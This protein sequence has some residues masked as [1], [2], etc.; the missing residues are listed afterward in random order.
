MD[1]KTLISAGCFVAFLLLSCAMA[2]ADTCTDLIRQPW[3]GAVVTSATRV[4]ASNG[5]PS[6]CKVKATAGK[7]TDIEVWLPDGWQKRFLHLGGGGL[8]GATPFDSMPAICRPHCYDRRLQQ[9]FALAGS[10]GGHRFGGALFGYDPELSED[11]AHAAI[12]TTAR[13]AK[14]LIAAYYGE[15]PTYSYFSGCSNGGR[16]ALNAAAKYPDE[17]DGIVAGAPTRNMAG[18]TAAWME[19]TPPRHVMTKG[20]ITALSKATV[21]ACDEQDGLVDGIISNPDACSFDPAELRCAGL[22]DDTCLTDEAIAYAEKVHSDLRLADGTL[23]Y[24]RTGPGL[25]SSALP[26]LW[27]S[28]YWHHGKS[29][30]NAITFRNPFHA[31]NLEADYPVLVRVLDGVY[32]YSAEADALARY[33][34]NGGRM[35]VWHG[36]DD[37]LVSHYD[38][39]RGFYEVIAAAGAQGAQNAKLY[40]VAGVGHCGGG[41]GADYFDMVSAVASWVEEGREP[42]GLIASKLDPATG[43][44]LLSRPICEYPAYPRYRSGSPVEAASFDCVGTEAGVKPGDIMNK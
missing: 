22:P 16:G 4:P 14:A 37:T 21:A 10:N 41:P 27:M 42:E 31:W 3:G 1:S 2:S 44:V 15:R 12:G 28:E 18:L 7:Q 11:Y 43:D 32:G 36:T 35:I 29:L 33:L 34:I 40:A 30:T 24:A 20:R 6:Y 19:F 13:V 8:D 25:L 5:I 39:V 26:Y 38:T 9:G 17:Y 23:I